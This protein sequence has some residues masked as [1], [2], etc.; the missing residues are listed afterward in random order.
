LDHHNTHRLV[1]LVQGV[2]VAMV[3]LGDQVVVPS[4]VA[5]S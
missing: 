2:V 3:V 4:G 5:A 1:V